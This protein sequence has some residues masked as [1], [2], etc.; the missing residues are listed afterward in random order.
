MYVNE[1]VCVCVCVDGPCRRLGGSDECV[2][3]GDQRCEGQLLHY[4]LGIYIH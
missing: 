1:S 4:P 2:V 3:V